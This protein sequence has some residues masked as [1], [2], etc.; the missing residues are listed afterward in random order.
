MGITGELAE[1]DLLSSHSPHCCSQLTMAKASKLES[2]SNAFDVHAYI[3]DLLEAALQEETVEKG[4]QCTQ[5]VQL[6]VHLIQNTDHSFYSATSRS[7]QDGESFI[8]S[9]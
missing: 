3:S 9:H 6:Q 8:G 1:V 4:V 2:T 7:E 5:F